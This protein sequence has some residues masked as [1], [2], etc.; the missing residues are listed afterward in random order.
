M[1]VSYEEGMKLKSHEEAYKWGKIGG[2]LNKEEYLKLV[3]LAADKSN[4]FSA[5]KYALEGNLYDTENPEVR[6]LLKE[7]DLTEKEISDLKEEIRAD[8]LKNGT[9]DFKKYAPINKK[10]QGKKQEILELLVSSLG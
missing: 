4:P 2:F 9:T 10:L 3:N 8:R 6:D 7:L 5:H 1:K